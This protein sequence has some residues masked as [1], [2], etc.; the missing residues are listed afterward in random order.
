M[1]MSASTVLERE[2]GRLIT[3]DQVLQVLMGNPVPVFSYAT[4]TKPLPYIIYNET[5]CESWDDDATLGAEHTILISVISEGESEAYVKNVLA[6]IRSLWSRSERR[7]NILPYR[8][9]LLNFTQ[10]D[11]QQEA[12][13]QAIRGTAQYRAL[14]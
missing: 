1:T 4:E 14:T 13:G 2:L 8:L 3:E 9:V 5:R 10:Q 12:D 6:R 7:L 11:I